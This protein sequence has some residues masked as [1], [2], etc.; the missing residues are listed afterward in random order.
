VARTRC[1]P[2]ARIKRIRLRWQAE[3]ERPNGRGKDA[4][5]GGGGTSKDDKCRY[6]GKK[7]HWARDCRKKKRDEEA[8]A[9]LVQEE[10]DADLA[11]LLAEIILDDVPSAAGPSTP[12]TIAGDVELARPL[13]LLN[14]EK[15]KV[16]PGRADEP[17]D[18]M[19]YLDT[20]ASNHMTGNRSA[21]T[22]LD[23][24]VTGNVRFGDGSVVQI[25]GKGDIAFSISGGRQRAFTDVYFIPRLKSSV[26]SLG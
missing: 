3:Q 26:V 9:H 20:G 2:P 22:T 14:E 18:A 21:F 6:C 11:M 23:E 8:Q 15:A 19:W 25:K 16:V 10:G 13:I 4:V 5:R 1:Q 17:M 24:S 7:G 12:A